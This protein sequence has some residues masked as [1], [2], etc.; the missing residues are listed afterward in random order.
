[1][2][3]V[4]QRNQISVAHSSDPDA[5]A[6]IRA[7]QPGSVSKDTDL[8]HVIAL[9][10]KLLPRTPASKAGAVQTLYSILLS[11]PQSRVLYSPLGGF[12]SGSL[13]L[14]DTEKQIQKKLPVRAFLKLAVRSLASPSHLLARRGWEKIIP[15]EKTGYIL[16]LGAT[17]PARGKNLL[18]E[19]EVHFISCGAKES[20]VDTE[21]SNQRAL[22]F[23]ERQGYQVVQSRLGHVLLRKSLEA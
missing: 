14:R 12:A 8:A 5:Q 21:R 13:S 16:T 10:Q 1:M 20:W 6:S 17:P 11:D 15:T 18:R 4:S 22:N 23:Y 9:H 19:L 2:D 7:I 3:L